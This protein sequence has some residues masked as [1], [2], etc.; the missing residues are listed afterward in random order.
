MEKLDMRKISSQVNNKVTK[1][2]QHG[3][4]RKSH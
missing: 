1:S 2:T 4:K 3:L